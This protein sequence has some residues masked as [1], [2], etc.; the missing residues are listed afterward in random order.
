MN[1]PPK[2]DPDE[3]APETPPSARGFPRIDL[4]QVAEYIAES[5]LG[6]YL[7]SVAAGLKTFRDLRRK[8]KD[9]EEIK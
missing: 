4:N 7:V 6:D 2:I 9:G 3:D 8:K 1:M 5:P